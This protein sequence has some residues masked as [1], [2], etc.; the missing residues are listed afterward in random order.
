[1]E[2]IGYEHV[3]PKSTVIEDIQRFIE[4]A[5]VQGRTVEIK[6]EW[7]FYAALPSAIRAYCYDSKL[8]RSQHVYSFDELNLEAAAEAHDRAEYERLREKFAA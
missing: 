1:M 7:P 3:Y 5:S 2:K 6:I 8:M 4:W